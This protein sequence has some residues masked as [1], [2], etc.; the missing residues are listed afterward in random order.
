MRDS[1]LLPP[2][3]QVQLYLDFPS[4]AG[5]PPNQLKGFQKV[6]LGPG[7][8]TTVSIALSQRDFS[9]W[10]VEAHRW[11]LVHGAFTMGVGGS[12][13]DRQLVGTVTM[14]PDG[15]GAWPNPTGVRGDNGVAKI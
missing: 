2:T 1:L 7:A 10:S 8:S 4:S 11:V 15:G 3:P 13:A 14:G 9:V 6:K 12:S 5:E